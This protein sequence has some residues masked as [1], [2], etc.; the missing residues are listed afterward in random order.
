MVYRKG[1]IGL[2]C[3]VTA[4]NSPSQ[5]SYLTFFI[6]TWST[7]ILSCSI[8]PWL[9]MQYFPFS[10]N[11]EWVRLD[12]KETFAVFCRLKKL[13][14]QSFPNHGFDW[15]PHSNLKPSDESE[16][17]KPVLTAMLCTTAFPVNKIEKIVKVFSDFGF[18]KVFF[19]LQSIDV[20]KIK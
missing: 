12:L 5:V 3:T 6:S 20:Y 1:Q 9:K 17:S 11:Q 18:L 13:E 7:A 2:R 15:R 16:K 19:S 10:K 8:H 14:K 4:S